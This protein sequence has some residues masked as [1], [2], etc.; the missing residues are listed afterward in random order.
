MTAGRGVSA[1]FGYVLTL[2]ISTLL[3]SGLIIA[4]G[5]FVDN[6]RELTSRSELRVI[7]QQVSGDIAAADRLVRS[8]GSTRTEIT[9]QIPERAVGS[10]YTVAVRTDGGGPTP[11]YLELR[12]VRPEVTVEVGIANETVVAGSEV[13]GG[14][15]V[16]RY[17]RSAGHLE[18]VESDA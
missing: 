18:V 6:Q 7:G 10:Q 16:V 13:G 1:V 4:A 3:V 15:I 9:R 11:A 5:G 12:T 2:G 17:D 8:G 14:E